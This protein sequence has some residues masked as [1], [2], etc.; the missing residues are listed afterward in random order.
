MH[1]TEVGKTL[2]QCDFDGTITEKDV[3]FLLLDA[4]ADG[5]WRQ[6]LTQYREGRISVN[7]FN[8]KAFAM[9]KADKQTLLNLVQGKARMRAGVHEL[10]TYCHKR[11]FQFVIVSNGLDFYIEAV[12]RDIDIDNIEVFAAQTRFSSEGIETRYIGPE[13]NQLENGFKEAYIRS[14]LSR[15]HRVVYV[16]N[17]ISDISPARQA[18]YI[19]ATSEL[20]T[21]CKEASLNCIPFVDLNDV[22]RG[23][24]LLPLEQES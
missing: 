14:F 19:F 22:V 4:F 24:E 6:L 2:V 13:G 1:S 5:D 12:L 7:N 16:G 17:G 23:L 3:S 20:L 10:I 11:G 15:G 8:T 21:Y 18:H 9:V